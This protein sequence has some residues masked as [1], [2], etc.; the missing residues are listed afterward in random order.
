M[1]FRAVIHIAVVAVEY[2]AVAGGVEE[3]QPL[4]QAAAADIGSLRLAAV[5]K[6]VA[7]NAGHA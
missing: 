1:L 6:V 5:A 4:Q 7:E 3:C 2:A